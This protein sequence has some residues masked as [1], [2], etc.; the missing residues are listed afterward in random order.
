MNYP[1]NLF[2]LIIIDVSTAIECFY[3][4]IHKLT[5]D[6]VIIGTSPFGIFP[7][8]NMH[9]GDW[10]YPS[11]YPFYSLVYTDKM[12]FLERV[13]NF[14]GTLYLIMYRIYVVRPNLLRIIRPFYGNEA[15]Y[16]MGIDKQISLFLINMDANIGYSRPITPNIIP[17]AGLHI[18]TKGFLPK[19][20]IS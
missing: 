9:T 19:V 4:F 7:W 3:P 8:L 20:S 5:N 2:D 10:I 16:S 18:Q 17:V 6:P 11:I 13:H 12:S 15:N 14:W 1:K